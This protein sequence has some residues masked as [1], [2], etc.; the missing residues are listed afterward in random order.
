MQVWEALCK[1]FRSFRLL[2]EIF[3]HWESFSVAQV[4]E[5]AVTSFMA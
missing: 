2:F 4:E 1:P 3:A 5:R